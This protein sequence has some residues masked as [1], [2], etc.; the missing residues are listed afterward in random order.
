MNHERAA[1]TAAELAELLV[2]TGQHHHHAYISSDGVDPEW[3]LWYAGYLQGRVWDRAG[4]IPTRSRLV[5][6]LL[7]AEQ[8]HAAYGGQAPWPAFYA[9]RMLS[10]LTAG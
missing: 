9:E 2:E 10:A 5:H 6:L 8:D 7:S 4:V 3:A 1:I